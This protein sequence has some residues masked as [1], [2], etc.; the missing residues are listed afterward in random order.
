MVRPRNRA[1]SCWARVAACS[2]LRWFP[3]TSLTAPKPVRLAV[4]ISAT[5]SAATSTSISVVASLRAKARRDARTQ[6]RAAC[7]GSRL[8][9]HRH[10]GCRLER[11]VSFSPAHARGRMLD[12]ERKERCNRLKAREWWGARALR[13]R[14]DLLLP[15]QPR[16]AA[17]LR[18]ALAGVYGVSVAASV[19]AAGRTDTAIARDLATLSGV[20][21][22]RFERG[23][24]EF[25]HAFTALFATRCPPTLDDRLAPGMRELLDQLAARGDRPLLAGHRQLR[26]GRALK[27]ERAGI[28]HHFA[29]GQGGFGSD[30]ESRD[31]LPAIARARAGGYPREQTIVIG[32]TPLDIACA[33]ADFAARAGGP[34][35]ART[36]AAELAH[37][38]AVA[39]DGW[40]WLRCSGPSSR[41]SAHEPLCS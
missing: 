38:D 17:A 5:S 3:A 37:A 34:R 8:G 10:Y 2:S 25:K 4:A 28:G 40:S 39:A 33:R 7:H 12:G 15:R 22:E 41:S 27:L 16:H 18:D 19:P 13:H 14:R 24:E 29:P 9:L 20:S 36:P 32:D 21:G 35:P 31:E 1:W 30:A 23:L 26:G 6:G 11:S